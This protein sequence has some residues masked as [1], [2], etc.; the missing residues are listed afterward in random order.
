MPLFKGK[1]RK[2]VNG[3]KNK[4]VKKGRFGKGKNE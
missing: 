4:K 2:M 3:G 1:K